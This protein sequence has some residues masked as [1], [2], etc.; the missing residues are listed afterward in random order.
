[1]HETTTHRT[2][3]LWKPGLGFQLALWPGFSRVA[4]HGFDVQRGVCSLHSCVSRRE[5]QTLKANFPVPMGIPLFGAASEMG[6]E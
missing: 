2:F 4:P 1:M 6:T 3:C 5:E